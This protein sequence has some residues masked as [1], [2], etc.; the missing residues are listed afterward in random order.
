[1]I[2]Q[3]KLVFAFLALEKKLGKAEIDAI[4]KFQKNKHESIVEAVYEVL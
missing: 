4:W 3:S 1:M 2:I